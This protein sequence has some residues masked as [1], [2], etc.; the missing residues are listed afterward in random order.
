[1]YESKRYEEAEKEYR[2][3]INLNPNDA[4]AHNDLGNLLV[5]H[6]NRYKEAE[7]EFRKADLLFSTQN[8]QFKN[9]NIK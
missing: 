5:Q 1:M 4:K 6:F 2:E 9:K 3:A 7:K 8:P